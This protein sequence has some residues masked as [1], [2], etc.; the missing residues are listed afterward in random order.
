M[1]DHGLDHSL[2]FQGKIVL[3]AQ[4]G[5]GLEEEKGVQAVE[6]MIRC[7]GGSHMPTTGQSETLHCPGY[8]PGLG[9][10]TRHMS[11]RGGS[12]RGLY[13][14]AIGNEMQSARLLRE[15]RCLKLLG[16]SCYHVA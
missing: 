8:S 16:V 1:D 7:D 4:L 6:G 12:I 10:G 2:V 14:Q 13:L 9:M 15:G 11:A 5:V 3:R